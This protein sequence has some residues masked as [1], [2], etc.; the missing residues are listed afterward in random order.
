M[1]KIHHLFILF[2]KSLVL[3]ETLKKYLFSIA[4]TLSF[5]SIPYIEGGKYFYA[6]EP[7]LL[8]FFLTC[9]MCVA[10]RLYTTSI[11]IQYLFLPFNSK[12]RLLKMSAYFIQKAFER[13]EFVCVEVL[14]T[15]QPS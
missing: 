14:L 1:I 6:N 13:G 11:N 5:K 12:I 8:S 9:V 10:I 15:S 4:S 3:C 2:R 7:S